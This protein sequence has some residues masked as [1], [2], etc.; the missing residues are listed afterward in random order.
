MRYNIF[1]FCV[2]FF[3]CYVNV[4][5]F[6]N[7]SRTGVKNVATM[8]CRK[9]TNV[10]VCIYQSMLVKTISIIGPTPHP[11]T[12]AFFFFFFFYQTSLDEKMTTKSF[13]L[14]RI[15]R[16]FIYIILYICFYVIIEAALLTATKLKKLT[17]NQ[18]CLDSSP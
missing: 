15:Y 13:Y 7:Y 16:I 14:L 5:F 6:A 9:C 2:L 10:Y 18:N 4:F 3:S 11:F 17:Q 8:T 1:C 12:R